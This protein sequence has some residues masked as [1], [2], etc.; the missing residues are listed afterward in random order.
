[1]SALAG[2]QCKLDA[3]LVRQ[4]RL[5]PGYDIETIKNEQTVRGQFV[6]DVVERVADEA[7]QQRVLIA[8]LRAL[9]GRN[10]LEVG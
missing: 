6:R 1:M 4:G 10:D 3:L 5:L 2:T 7:L 8:G 9:S